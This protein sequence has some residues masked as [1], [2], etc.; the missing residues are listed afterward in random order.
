MAKQSP[1]GC[2]GGSSETGEEQ[3]ARAVGGRGSRSRPVAPLGG[4]RGRGRLG[5]PHAVQ[6]APGGLEA[7]PTRYF[8]WLR[9][10]PASWAPTPAGVPAGRPGRRAFCLLRAEGP[11]GAAQQGAEGRAPLPSRRAEG[12]SRPPGVWRPA[13][14]ERCP[15]PSWRS[16]PAPASRPSSAGRGAVS[17]QRNARSGQSR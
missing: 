15:R 3:E 17:Q 1:H 12:R 16:H 9:C 10:H 11:A 2:I 14:L 6:T 5:H 8:T 13:L 7:G 4:E